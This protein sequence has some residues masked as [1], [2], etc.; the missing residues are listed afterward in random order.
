MLVVKVT[1]PLGSTACAACNTVVGTAHVPPSMKVTFP[2]V[3]G[4]A[5]LATVAVKTT[6]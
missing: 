2:T 6:D 5:P 1:C 4:V 3:T